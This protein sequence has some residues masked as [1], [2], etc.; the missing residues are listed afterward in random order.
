MERNGAAI[1]I[2]D[3]ELN[4]E[5]LAQKLAVLLEDDQILAEM[6]AASKSLGKPDAAEKIAQSALSLSVKE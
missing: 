3:A 4:G 2:D 5:L 1:L 6:S